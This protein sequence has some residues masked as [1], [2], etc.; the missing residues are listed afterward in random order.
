M[1]GQPKGTCVGLHSG[2]V[3]VL[4]SPTQGQEKTSLLDTGKYQ[5]S[6]S[7]SDRECLL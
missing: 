3:P 4:S 5:G 6:V 1:G 2:P 7:L